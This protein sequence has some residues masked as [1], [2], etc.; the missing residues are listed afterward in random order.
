VTFSLRVRNT[1]KRKGKHVVMLFG[2]DVVRRVSPEV[3]M[4][5]AF[6]KTRELKPGETQEVAFTLHPK[7]DLAL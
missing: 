2:S 4:L 5:K 3:K 7:E 1:G 6:A